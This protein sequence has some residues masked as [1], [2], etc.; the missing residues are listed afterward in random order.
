VG[1]DSLPFSVSEP[2]IFPHIDGLL[3][4]IDERT[5]STSIANATGWACYPE[6]TPC[7]PNGR[8]GSGVK[9]MMKGVNSLVGATMV[10]PLNI[11][12]RE[13]NSN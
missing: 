8:Q 9:G 13:L 1:G 11:V 6:S 10:P 12:K 7:A 4:S 5:H 3:P 2:E